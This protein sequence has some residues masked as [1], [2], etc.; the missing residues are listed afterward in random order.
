ME[1]ASFLEGIG[2]VGMGDEVYILPFSCD[3]SDFGL[4]CFADPWNYG[5]DADDAGDD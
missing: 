1:V 3:Y 4:N 2:R 5:A